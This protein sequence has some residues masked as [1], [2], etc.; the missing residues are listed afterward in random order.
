MWPFADEQSIKS[1]TVLPFLQW[2][3]SLRSYLSNIS[4]MSF[5]SSHSR[6]SLLA[7]LLC[8][9]ISMTFLS[10]C[11]KTPTEPG[12]NSDVP[13]FVLDPTLVHSTTL[14][15]WAWTND[16]SEAI[17]PDGRYLLIA[18]HDS[19]ATSLVAYPLPARGS[20]KED[21]KSGPENGFKDEPVVLRSIGRQWTMDKGLEYIPMGWLS[22]TKCLFVSSG[23]QNQGKHRN[24]QGLSIL[25]GDISNKQVRELT[26]IPLEYAIVREAALDPGNNRLILDASDLIITVDLESHTANTVK[27]EPPTFQGSLAAELS[28]DKTAYVYNLHEPDKYGVYL[29]DLGTGAETP[30][31]PTGDTLSFYPAWSPD[32]KYVAAYTVARK[33]GT[34]EA[35][36]IN[37]SLEHYEVY[38]GEDSPMPFGASI[39][40]VD[41]AGQKINEI[42]VTGRILGHFKWSA[43]SKYLGFVSCAKPSQGQTQSASGQNPG[44]GAPDG[45]SGTEQHSSAGIEGNWEIPSLRADSMWIADVT[46]GGTAKVADLSSAPTGDTVSIYPLAFSP[47]SKGLFYQVIQ[48]QSSSIWYGAKDQAQPGQTTPVKVADGLWYENHPLPVFDNELSAIIGG[49]GSPGEPEGMKDTG[50][51]KDSPGVS[52][53]LLGGRG[54]RN[55]SRWPAV[56]GT[57]MAHDE[58][59]LVIY[60]YPGDDQFEI[61]VYSMYKGIE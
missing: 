37:Y 15:G 53:W 29:L 33:A 55:V 27:Q 35:D 19:D 50:D 46:T 40:I 6:P 20:H 45:E 8:L 51:T 58:H 30:L 7:L 12:P 47:D 13:E 41:K 11:V 34:N 26:F 5:K 36:S 21:S 54:F 25:E 38:L 18:Q 16:P 9:S 52:L 42:A 60:S 1:T 43:D 44:P 28:P 49:T 61:R 48:E 59:T 10:G 2:L 56:T 31:M 32:G 24:Q 22:N 57:I 23:L 3:P 4:N 39:T 17:S 14:S